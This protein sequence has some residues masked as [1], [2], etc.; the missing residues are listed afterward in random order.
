MLALKKCL[1]YLSIPILLFLSSGSQ[2]QTKVLSGVI[3]DLQS[4][5][6]VPFASMRLTQSGHGKLSDSAGGFP[7]ISITAP[8]R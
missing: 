5:E 8:G 4:G 1:Y 7:F 2:A 6:R 3:M